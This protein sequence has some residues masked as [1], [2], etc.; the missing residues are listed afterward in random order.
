MTVKD[1]E[2][3]EINVHVE[4]KS[5][6]FSI[7]VPLDMKVHRFIEE[8]IKQIGLRRTLGGRTIEYLLYTREQRTNR[9]I[10]SFYSFRKNK[11]NNGED[12][13]LVIHMGAK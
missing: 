1:S 11:V 2:V 8:L 9:L 4:S 3:I 7:S 6:V 13:D 10:D 12:L 5:K